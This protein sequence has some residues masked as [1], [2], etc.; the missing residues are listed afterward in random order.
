MPR[1]TRRLTLK[2]DHY[3]CTVCGAFTELQVHHIVPRRLGGSDELS[4]LV[5]LCAA[6]HL[7]LHHDPEEPDPGPDPPA[8]PRGQETR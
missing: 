4:N 3:R 6:C 8:A 1:A 7:Q 2:R 5:T